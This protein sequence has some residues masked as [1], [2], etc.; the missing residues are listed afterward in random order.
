MKR[1]LFLLTL[2]FT[3]FLSKA[4]CDFNLI[5]DASNLKMKSI[6]NLDTFY[7]SARYFDLG[8][9]PQRDYLDSLKKLKLIDKRKYT[10]AL[11]FTPLG[12]EH[13]FY[14]P[15]KEEDDSFYGL[16]S[17]KERDWGKK[18]CIRGIKIKGFETWGWKNEPFFLIDKVWIE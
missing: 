9:A 16:L 1:L 6:K 8:K 18:I 13:S 5:L 11:G 10:S 2:F 7:F 15:I 3:F 17:L 14:L 12:S 4:Q